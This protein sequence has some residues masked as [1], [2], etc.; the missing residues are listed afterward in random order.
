M[1]YNRSY[2]ICGTLLITFDWVG[3]LSKV[4]STDGELV[5]GISTTFIID[6]VGQMK[7][8]VADSENILRILLHGALCPEKNSELDA[9]V[10]KH[11][12]WFV[13]VIRWRNEQ[14]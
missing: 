10:G 12:N 9:T 5:F 13:C 2:K 11:L 3:T 8:F 7:Y 14:L 1:I 4:L 6:T